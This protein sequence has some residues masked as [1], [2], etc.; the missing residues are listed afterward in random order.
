MIVGAEG[1]Y[2]IIS[3]NYTKRHGEWKSSQEPFIIIIYEKTKI[4][5]KRKNSNKTVVCKMFSVL[6]IFSPREILFSNY[7]SQVWRKYL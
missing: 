5:D 3:W 7:V 2:V 6:I 1:D 4:T